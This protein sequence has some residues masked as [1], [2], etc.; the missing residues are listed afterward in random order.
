MA[1]SSSLSRDGGALTTDSEDADDKDRDIWRPD[2]KGNRGL[3]E[4]YD[5]VMYGKLRLYLSIISKFDFT[6][7]FRRC[8]GLILDL[9]TLCKLLAC[10]LSTASRAHIT[11][12]L[13]STAY[14]SFGGLLLS[15]AGS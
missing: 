10:L 13:R 12:I 3:E 9:P 14:A 8:I 1:L 2:G 5:Y 11:Y 4:D 15:I 7:W 6:R